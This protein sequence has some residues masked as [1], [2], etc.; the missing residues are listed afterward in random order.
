MYFHSASALESCK[1]TFNLFPHGLSPLR[2][3]VAPALLLF[4]ERV[5]QT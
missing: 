1:P 4:V 2:R 5:Q 3:R